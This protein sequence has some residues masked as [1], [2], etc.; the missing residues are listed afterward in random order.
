MSLIMLKIL[1]GI[2]VVSETS[3]EE[4]KAADGPVPDLVE[5]VM[6]AYTK[7]DITNQVR[8]HNASIFTSKEIN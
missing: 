4:L 1:T 8:L 5:G 6:P 7:P 3:E 2:C